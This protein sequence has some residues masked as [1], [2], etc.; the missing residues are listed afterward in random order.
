MYKKRF[1]KWGFQKNAKRSTSAAQ[2]WAVGSGCRKAASSHFSTKSW[3]LVSPA[4]SPCLSFHDTLMSS[5]MTSVHTYSIA[6]FESMQAPDGHF[7]SLQQQSI[8]QQPRAEETDEISYAFKLAIELLDRGYGSFA[9]RMAR[10]AFLLVED[11]LTLDGPV[12]M[13]NLFEL[14]HHMAKLG[15]M[16]LFQMLLTH[17]IGLVNCRRPKIHP[18]ATMLHDLRDLVTSLSSLVSISG[19][20]RATRASSI[21]LQCPSTDN[22]RDPS[23]AGIQLFSHALSSLLERAWILNAAILLKHFD[24]RLFRIYFHVHWD[25]CSIRP[26]IA[27]FGA[28]KQWL[29][30]VE[31]Q[32]TFSTA[33]EAPVD[34]VIFNSSLS[35]KLLPPY[36]DTPPPQDYEALHTSSIA[37]LWKYG[38]SILSEDPENVNTT[39]LLRIL[40]GLFTA[41]TLERWSTAVA[42]FDPKS[43]TMTQI[44]RVHASNVACAIQTLTNLNSEH[45]GEEVWQSLDAAERIRSIVALRE[46]AHGNA[47]P[48]I[49]G[50][51]WRLQDALVAA[52]KDKE[53]WEV[54]QTISRR[55]EGYIQDMPTYSV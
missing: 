44:S 23:I 9:G 32:Q 47:Y 15:H 4:T 7:L 21:L 24:H 18:L 6:F 5:F 22:K 11:M 29:G 31:Q 35:Q 34:Q 45:V 53:S 27:I 38:S 13:W 12:I 42:Q 37:A 1:T 20:S 26:P 41:E 3:S 48:R 49:V 25:L 51:M 2:T 43:S 54:G 40:A 52:G 14:F 36:Q 46:Y 39:V 16:Q 33:M 17:L 28:L 30:H 19:S 10:K 50:D 8:L 55:I